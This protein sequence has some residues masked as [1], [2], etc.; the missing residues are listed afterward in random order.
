M[1]KPFILQKETS[2]KAK[3]VVRNFKGKFIDLSGWFKNKEKARN[4]LDKRIK[5]YGPSYGRY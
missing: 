2:G 5:E 4:I 1:N 3:I